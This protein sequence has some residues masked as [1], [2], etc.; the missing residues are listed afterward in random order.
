MVSQCYVYKWTHLPTLNWYVG[1]RTSKGCH[2]NDGYICS[3]LI[4]KPL[5][6]QNPKD[7]QREII[8]V[9]DAIDMRLLEKEILRL[10]SAK[11]DIRSY[12]QTNGPFYKGMSFNKGKPGK[13]RKPRTEETKKKLSDYWKGKK[14]SQEAIA[15]QVLSRKQNQ[16]PRKKI[17]ELEQQQINQKIKETKFKNNTLHKNRLFSPIQI[18]FIRNSELSLSKL[19]VMMNVSRVTISKVKNNHCY[20]DVSIT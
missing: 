8:A 2:P 11:D 15:K 18:N 13:P 20:K 1:S 12:N 19:A 3:S 6:K 5:I 4:V 7:W 17:T 10:F 14:K 9:G 16:K